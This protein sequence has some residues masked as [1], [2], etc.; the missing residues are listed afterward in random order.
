MDQ[1]EGIRLELKKILDEINEVLKVLDQV[2]REKTAS[3]EE[4]GSLRESLRLL[5]SDQGRPR[6]FRDGTPVRRSPPPE[7]EFTTPEAEAPPESDE[8][9]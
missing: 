7:Q 5:H 3:E 9:V 8:S 6:H 4:I 2:E 1:V